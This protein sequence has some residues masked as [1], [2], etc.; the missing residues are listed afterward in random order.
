[1]T[2]G[3]LKYVLIIFLLC[4]IWIQAGLPGNSLQFWLAGVIAG[5]SMQDGGISLNALWTSNGKGEPLR[6]EKHCK[7]SHK[8]ISQSFLPSFIAFRSDPL[9]ILFS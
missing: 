8:K 1:M 9:K 6:V 2:I 3:M 4:F 7:Q 5:E